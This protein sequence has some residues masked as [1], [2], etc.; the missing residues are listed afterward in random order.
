MP[1]YSSK[2]CTA[3]GIPSAFSFLIVSGNIVSPLS[4]K[5]RSGDS[6]NILES[7]LLFKSLFVD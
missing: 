1:V 5:T 7:I 4:T 2:T 6:L 3:V